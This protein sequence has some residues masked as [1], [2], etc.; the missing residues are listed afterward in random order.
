MR[1]LDFDLDTIKSLLS[2]EMNELES[3][4]LNR[5]SHLENMILDLQKKSKDLDAIIEISSSKKQHYSYDLKAFSK[6][7]FFMNLVL[8]ISP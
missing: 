6:R 8:M 3:V 2:G 7:S 1:S 5:K 4:L